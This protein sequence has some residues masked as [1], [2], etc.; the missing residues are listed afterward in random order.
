[1][2]NRGGI[3]RMDWRREMVEQISRVRP[4]LIRSPDMPPKNVDEVRRQN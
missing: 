1:M 2:I 4:L 3:E